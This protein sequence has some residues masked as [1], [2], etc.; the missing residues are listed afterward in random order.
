MEAQPYYQSLLDQGYTT[1]QALQYTLQ[2]YPDFVIATPTPVQTPAQ[3]AFPAPQFE[4]PLPSDGVEF[5]Q[6]VSVET[7]AANRVKMISIALVALVIVGGGTVGVLYAVGVLGVKDA[8]FVGEWV[9]E[10]GHI[11]TFN[12]NGT[13]D[14]YPWWSGEPMESWPFTT[15]W[16]KSGDEVTTLYERRVTNEEFPYDEKTNVVMK[17]NIVGSVMFMKLLQGTQIVDYGDGEVYEI[18]LSD[19]EQE[20]IATISKERFDFSGENWNE[21]AHNEWYSMVNSVDPPSWCDNDFKDDYQFTFSKN[22]NFF[23]LTLEK[24]KWEKLS[25][26][27]MKFYITINGGSEIECLY[28]GYDGVCSYIPQFGSEDIYADSVISFGR[29]QQWDTDCSSGCN[30]DIRIVQN[31]DN[32]PVVIDEFSETSLV[33]EQD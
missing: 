9:D 1:D 25:I 8:N 18:E 33:W 14:Q 3:P 30:L 32:G 19:I 23:E 31:T 7:G 26:S 6:P 20:C 24:S 10:G 16:E 13:I 21:D 4:M 27:D 11:T 2:Y 22:D 17:I 5:S 15:S 12:D 28:D 29:A